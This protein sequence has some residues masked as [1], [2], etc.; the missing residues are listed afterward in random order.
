MAIAP[1]SVWAEEDIE[2]ELWE[3]KKAI[4]L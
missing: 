4:K 3:L 1:H 2:E